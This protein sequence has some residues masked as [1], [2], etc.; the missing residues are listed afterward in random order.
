MDEHFVDV[1]APAAA[2][3]WFSGAGNLVALGHG[4]APG[5]YRVL[6]GFKFAQQ[7]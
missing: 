1:P 5:A 2:A 7:Q 3:A 4:E 6:R